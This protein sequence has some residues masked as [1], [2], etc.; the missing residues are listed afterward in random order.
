MMGWKAEEQ[1]NY[2]EI[3]PK[4]KHKLLEQLQHMESKRMDFRKKTQENYRLL[5][6][7]L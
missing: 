6:N 5:I 2:S 1:D 3:D 7:K 4:E